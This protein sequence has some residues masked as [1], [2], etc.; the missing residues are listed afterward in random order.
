MHRIIRGISRVDSQEHQ[1][2]YIQR[3]HPNHQTTLRIEYAPHRST[4]SYGILKL[5]TYPPHEQAHQQPPEEPVSKNRP[6]ELPPQTSY[7]EEQI[8][9]AFSFFVNCT[10]L[11]FLCFFKS[12]PLMAVG[13]FYAV[14]GCGETDCPQTGSPAIFTPIGSTRVNRLLLSP[15]NG[16]GSRNC[17][18]IL[19]SSR[20]TGGDSRGHQI[21]TYYVGFFHVRCI[22]VWCQNLSKLDYRNMSSEFSCHYAYAVTVEAISSIVYSK[23]GLISSRDYSTHMTLCAF[24]H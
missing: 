8:Q 11:K 15:A 14:I 9:E 22:A 4:P 23:D 24:C 13:G 19:S 2:E 1:V 21:P 17:R 3:Y 6:R 16:K 20:R 18:A 10:Q 12:G 7:E 5:H